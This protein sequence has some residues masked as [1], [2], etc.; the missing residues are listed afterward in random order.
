M[1]NQSVL[2]QPQP[3]AAPAAAP[4]AKNAN[5]PL[6]VGICAGGAVLI[7][8][9][10]WLI[11]VLVSG[12]GGSA[13]IKGNTYKTV[14]MIIDGQSQK[15]DLE[16]M[17]KQTGKEY[18]VF[19]FKDNGECEVKTNGITGPKCTYNDSTI[20]ISNS[21]ANYKVNGNRIEITGIGEESNQTMILEKK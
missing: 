20:T 11:I 15:S 2:N 6:I 3:A 7:G 14:D 16:E 13:K 12:G 10:V 19:T 17:E 18:M 21:A 5:T 1:E 8:L 4:K 9:V